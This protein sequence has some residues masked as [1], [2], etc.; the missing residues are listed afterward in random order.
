ME[1]HAE[2][3]TRTEAATETARGL[4]REPLQ[5]C[6]QHRQYCERS[7]GRPAARARTGHKRHRRALNVKCRL[8]APSALVQFSR[9]NIAD[10]FNAVVGVVKEVALLGLGGLVVVACL[11]DWAVRTRRVARSAGSRDSPGRGSIQHMT[12]VER[13]IVRAGGVPSSAPLWMIVGYAL[14]GILVVERV[15]LLGG[16]LAQVAYGGPRRERCRS[17]WPRGR[18]R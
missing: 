9:V 1:S 10:G 17:C 14:L 15:N 11:L 3:R 12:P 8:A 18:F 2:R 4:E 7:R 13:V 16:V 5:Y 6:R